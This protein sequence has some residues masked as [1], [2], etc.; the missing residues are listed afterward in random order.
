MNDIGRYGFEKYGEQSFQHRRLNGDTSRGDMVRTIPDAIAAH[1]HAHFRMHLNGVP[2][3]YF[4]TR[5]HQLA[6]VAFN[7]MMEFYFAGL[8][9]EEPAANIFPYTP[10]ACPGHRIYHQQDVTGCSL[11][12]QQTAA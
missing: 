6:A 3:D 9:D 10:E 7:A 2:H 5:R 4:N 1:A 12:G 8:E 11:C